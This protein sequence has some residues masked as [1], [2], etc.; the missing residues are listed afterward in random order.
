MIDDWN[1]S[2]KGSWKWQGKAES[3]RGFMEY[4]KTLGAEILV[5]EGCV[6]RGIASH[7]PVPVRYHIRWDWARRAS[8]YK[9]GKVLL[10]YFI[11]CKFDG[12][13]LLFWIP[14]IIYYVSQ[15]NAKCTLGI[16]SD[17]ILLK[18]WNLHRSVICT[19]CSYSS[20]TLRRNMSLSTFNENQW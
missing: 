1:F 5:P 7:W 9:C 20:L 13:H 8:E 18:K 6:G 19:R 15:I 4:K 10:T 3:S 11:V 2:L 16:V 17:I 12:V 14:D